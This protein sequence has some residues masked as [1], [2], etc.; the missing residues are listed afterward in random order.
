[1]VDLILGYL[2]IG[3]VN[4]SFYALLSLGLALI[5]GLLNVLQHGA[6]GILYDG[7]ICRL[8]LRR[9]TSE[10]C[11]YLATLAV[12]AFGVGA[13]GMLLE[14]SS[15]CAGPY[16]DLDPLYGF[17]LTFGSATATPRGYFRSI[18]SSTGLQPSRPPDWLAGTVDPRLPLSL[19]AYRAL[20]R[21]SSHSRSASDSGSSLSK[22][23]LERRYAPHPRIARSPRRLAYGFQRS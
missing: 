13:V 12:A 16:H 14:R 23:R 4:G 11:G 20:G 18:S 1:M 17:M 15:C 21:P 8:G 3:L 6:R 22:P 7:R 19:P 10:H 9:T 5:F 2:T